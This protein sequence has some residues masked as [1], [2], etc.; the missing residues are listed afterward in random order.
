MD[1]H[2]WASG[3]AAIAAAVT[4]L[5]GLAALTRHQ[6]RLRPW[7]AVLLGINAGY[8]DVSMETLRGRRPVDVL[9]LL[10]GGA[11][12]SGFWPGPGAPHVV[13]MW[14]AIGQPVLG[15]VLL[16]LTRYVGRSGLLGGGLVLS[17]LM[18]VDDTDVAAGVLGLVA[19]LL[20]L[21]GDVLTRGR[22]SRTLAAVLL[23]GYAALVVWFLW[24]A[25]VLLAVP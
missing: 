11:A 9:L 1:L 7:L 8:G 20:L 10:L 16:L 15:V 22:P 14:L 25:A 24:I 3:G 13:W 12:Y 6:D 5:L 23:C 21:V 4:L 2:S 18:L 19:G 17:V